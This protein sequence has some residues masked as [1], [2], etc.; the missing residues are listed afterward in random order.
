MRT[1]IITKSLVHIVT[2]C[3]KGLGAYRVD[4]VIMANWRKH[5]TKEEND[6]IKSNT[7]MGNYMVLILTNGMKICL[8]STADTDWAS[9]TM[10]VHLGSMS[11]PDDIPGLAHFCEHLLF[12]GS[13]KY[14]AENDF[15][16]LRGEPLDNRR[17]ARSFFEQNCLSLR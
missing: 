3:A 6:I 8:M 7:D 14:P 13:E 2:I 17:G 9:A 4:T 5:V 11:D 1:R 12:M 16:V 15:E 10:D